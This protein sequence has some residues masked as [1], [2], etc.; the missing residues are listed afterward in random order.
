MSKQNKMI[1]PNGRNVFAIDDGTRE[2]TMVNKFGQLV[3]KIHFR[4]AELAIV[5]RF[6]ELKNDFSSIIAPL[7]RINI[8]ADGTTNDDDESW[9]VLKQVEGQIKRR[10]NILLDTDDADEIFKTRFPFSSV[11]GRFFVENV[12]DVLGQAITAHVEEEAQLSQARIKKYVDDL[13]EDEV[14]DGAG[15]SA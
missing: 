6:N 1:V 11:G 3:C 12:L 8:N 13:P 2:I 14:T 15:V 5:D 4:T 7:S 9:A 10:L